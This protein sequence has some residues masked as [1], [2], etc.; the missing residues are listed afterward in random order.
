M[1]VATLEAIGCGSISMAD[2]DCEH[3]FASTTVT[4]YVPPLKPRRS[5][6]D[7][8]KPFDPVQS[9]VNG[10]VPPAMMR[11]MAPSVAPAQLM[12]IPPNTE[13]DSVVLSSSGAVSVAPV[14]SAQPFWSVMET[15]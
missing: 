13:G 6:V 8:V 7:A 12:F 9:W 14:F 15:V 1:L 11:S 10:A 5:S 3:P 4:L 2:A